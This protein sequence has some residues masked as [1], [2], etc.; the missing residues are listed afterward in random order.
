MRIESRNIRTHCD[1]RI[2]FAVKGIPTMKKTIL[3]LLVGAAMAFGSSA[4]AQQPMPPHTAGYLGAPAIQAGGGGCNSCANGAGAGAGYGQPLAFKRLF[5]SH[6]FFGLGGGRTPPQTLPVAQQ[7]MGQL[8]FPQN[9]FVR[10]PR[11]FFMM[12]GR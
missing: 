7:G 3:A 2:T 6:P 4:S 1:A 12:D 11:D 9:P 8:A 10:S 5:L